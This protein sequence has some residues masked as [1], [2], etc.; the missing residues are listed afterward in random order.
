MTDW[1]NIAV[2]STATIGLVNIFDSHLITRRMPSI[3]AFMLLAGL[4][5]LPFAIAFAFLFPIASDIRIDS[6]GLGIIS[7]VLRA[8]GIILLLY[9]LRVEEVSRA[10]PVYNIFP[11]FVAILAVLLLGETL[12]FFQWLAIIIVVGGAIVISTRWENGRPSWRIGRIFYLLLFASIAIALANVS[13]KYVLE[14]FS[15]WNLYWLN[16]AVLAALL[17]MLSLRKKIFKEIGSIKGKISTLGILGFNESLVLLASVLL[18]IA[19]QNGQVSLVSTIVSSRPLFV[20]FFAF[21]ISRI[22]PSF[23]IWEYGKEALT[24]RLVATGMIVGGISI[25]YLF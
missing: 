24:M 10:V 15:Y 9:V 8:T 7:S 4:F 12:G 3:N 17:I 11:V 1:I 14:S 5:I 19:I 23:L 6:I 21:V 18:F 13:A 2:L 20:L 25:I 16:S 22:W